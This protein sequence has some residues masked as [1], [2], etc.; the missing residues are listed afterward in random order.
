MPLVFVHGVANRPSIEQAA[1]IAQR[2][3]LFRTITFGSDAVQVFNPDWGKNA[4]SFTTRMPW[5]PDP[6]NIQP[7][8]A[9][10]VALDDEASRDVGLGR[11]AKVDG[12]QAI[13]LAILAALEEAV[14]AAGKSDQPGLAADRELLRLAKTA[15]D[16]LGPSMPDATADP[17]GIVELAAATDQEFAG[18]LDAEF[19]MLVG[20]D[21]QAFGIGDKIRAAVGA[22]GGWIG[23]GVSDAALRAKRRT[24]SQGV[25]LFLGDI[26]VYLRQRRDEGPTGT[27]ARLFEPILLNLIEAA[28]VERA[29]HE[30]FVV[31]GHSLGG[32][33]LYDILTDEAC[34]QR[35]RDKAPDFKIDAWLTVGSQPGFFADLGLYPDRPKNAAGRFDKPTNVT[36]WLN[37]YDFTDVFSFLC[38]PFFDSV[39]DFGYDTTVDLIHAHSAY[40]KRPSFYKRLQARLKSL[41]YL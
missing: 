36:N 8:A 24:L 39:D 4:V 25:A 11:I 14:V 34:L 32:V 5:L 30:P 19:Q 7:F 38:K 13:D 31:V 3:A 16:Y 1:E 6:G 41:G 23:N 40:F 2:D 21:L 9:G 35:L 20:N 10:D 22:L 27:T 18:A 17:K 29:P 37:I 15:A 28:Q 12:A 26:F 33:L